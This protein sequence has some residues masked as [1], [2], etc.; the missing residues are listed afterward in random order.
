MPRGYRLQLGLNRLGLLL[1]EGKRSLHFLSR[2]VDF[3]LDSQQQIH[4]RNHRALHDRSEHRGLDLFVLQLHRIEQFD[5]LGK[6]AGLAEALERLRHVEKRVLGLNRCACEYSAEN[7][8]RRKRDGEEGEGLAA[9]IDGDLLDEVGRKES[10]NDMGKKG[11]VDG[12][13]VRENGRKGTEMP[14]GAEGNSES[15]EMIGFSMVGS[16]KR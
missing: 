7:G 6:E 5:I 4:I 16:D 2:F 10:E 14:R 15:W 12:L 11:G 3:L 1:H 13:R 8:G 9:T